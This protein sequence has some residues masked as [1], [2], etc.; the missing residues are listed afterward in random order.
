MFKLQ[1][2]IP[3]LGDPKHLDCKKMS[4]HTEII[5]SKH[6][7]NKNE[8]TNINEKSTCKVKKCSKYDQTS[9]PVVLRSPR[10]VMSLCQQ[11]VVMAEALTTL[12]S[13]IVFQ[14]KNILI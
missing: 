6:I 1:R 13:F 11:T 10:G 4:S 12:Y 3:Q 7:L 5:G 8:N 9:A 2:Y 14:V